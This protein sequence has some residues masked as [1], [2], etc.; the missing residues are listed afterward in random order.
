MPVRTVPIAGL[1]DLEDPPQAAGGHKRPCGDGTGEAAH[2]RSYLDDAPRLLDR[3]HRLDE[4]AHVHRQRL[5][6]VHVLAG[7]DGVAQHGAVLMVRRAD[8]DR[9]NVREREDVV[10][11]HESLRLSPGRLTHRGG[12]LPSL[13]A[14]GV[15]DCQDLDVHF[16][17]ELEDFP[18]Q[19]SL[20]AADHRHAEA[21]VGAEKAPRPPAGQRSD[22]KELTA[23]AG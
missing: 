13:L 7:Q 16:L 3:I 2:L 1:L 22:T 23:V 4:F 19:A 21:V 9:V 15:A 6:D 10:V 14:P 8:H 20:T 5:F 18:E 17:G 12:R 11:M